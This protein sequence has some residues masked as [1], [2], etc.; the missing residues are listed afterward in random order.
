[1]VAPQAEIKQMK[2]DLWRPLDAGEIIQVG[3]E[4]D[5]CSDPW[6]DDAKWLPVTADSPRVGQPVPDPR[7]PAHTRFRRK[8]NDK[9]YAEWCEVWGE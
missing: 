6:R 9:E 2:H 5:G 7:F 8:L 1:M 4:Y 3:D